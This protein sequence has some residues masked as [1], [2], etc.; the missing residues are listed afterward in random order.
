MVGEY[1]LNQFRPLLHLAPVIRHHH[2]HWE[3]LGGYHLPEHSALAA[4]LIYLADRIDVLRAKQR[5][6]GITSPRELAA[7]ITG[8]L[9]D[10][11][12]SHFAP[13]LVAAFAQ[14]AGNDSFWY[15]LEP[16]ELSDFIHDMEREGTTQLSDFED[17][18]QL[19]QIF[20]RIVDAKSDFTY[21]H[22]VGVARLA[23]HLAELAGL[24]PHQIEL[25]E[26]AALLHDLGK[27]GVPDELLE[28][29]GPL[30]REEA[31]VMHRHSYETFR[32]L[33]HIKGFEEMAE[34]AGNHHETLLGNGYPFRHRNSEL[35]IEAR[36]IAVADAFDA[37]S[38]DR[39]FHKRVSVR[40]AVGEIVK[41][42]GTQFDPRVVQ[43][44]R[45]LAESGRLPAK[46]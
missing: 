41:G 11:S 10:H 1:Y 19:A 37:L 35:S 46:E 30:T 2:T 45:E 36:I 39:P 42:A 21:N 40:S 9:Q 22:S 24:P 32:I 26:I 28:K 33:R 43:A 6:A 5:K 27:L 12:P 15:I 20:A 18:Y 17:I 7:T 14:I 29:A 34:W 4:N 38:R 16:L 13:E 23:R 25:I 44:F 3:E 31:E 8:I